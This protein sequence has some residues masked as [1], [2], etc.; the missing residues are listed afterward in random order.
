MRT[1][2]VVTCGH[3]LNNGD[4]GEIDLRYGDYGAKGQGGWWYKKEGGCGE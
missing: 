2:M 1:A 4:E 3:G